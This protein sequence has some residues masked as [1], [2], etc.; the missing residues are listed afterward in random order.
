MSFNLPQAIQTHW[1]AGSGL[2]SL[3]LEYAP[4]TVVLPIAILEATGFSR[5][6]L[7]AGLKEDSFNFKISVITT[8]AE[9]TWNQAESAMAHMGNLDDQKIVSVEI[10][11][12]KLAKPAKLGQVDVWVFEFSLDIKVFDN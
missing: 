7:S 3:W 12:D 8:S 1:Q 2:P 9:T 4:E 11:P 10:S 6:Y 5:N